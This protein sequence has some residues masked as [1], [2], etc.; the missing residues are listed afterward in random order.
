MAHLRQLPRFESS[1]NACALLRASL[2]EEEQDVYADELIRITDAT[3]S[4]FGR[5]IAWALANATPRH[6]CLAFLAAKGIQ[7]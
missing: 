5:R 2:S 1:L 3:G 4:L 7:V 6:H